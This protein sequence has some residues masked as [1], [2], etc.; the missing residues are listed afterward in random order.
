[1]ANLDR[2]P[3]VDVEKVFYDAL[4]QNGIKVKKVKAG[5]KLP[6]YVYIRDD[7]QGI[8]YKIPTNSAKKVKIVKSEKIN[9]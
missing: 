3:G 5:K 4:E 1:M 7:E 2:K 8:I 9:K 6:K